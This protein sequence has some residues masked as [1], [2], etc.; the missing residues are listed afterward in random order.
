MSATWSPAVWWA[1][2]RIEVTLF[3][4]VRQYEVRYIGDPFLPFDS[5][6]STNKAYSADCFFSLVSWS[7]SSMPP[8]ARLQIKNARAPPWSV[9]TVVLSRH[10]AIKSAVNGSCACAPADGL[11][12]CILARSVQE[13][14][15]SAQDSHTHVRSERWLYIT[16]Y[17]PPPSQGGNGK[18]RTRDS[19]AKGIICKATGRGLTVAYIWQE[20]G[21]PPSSTTTPAK[22]YAILNYR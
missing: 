13:P 18:E 6:G 3:S 10:R 4:L 8:V 20:R 19:M 22:K 7:G 1:D 15:A 12:R 9:E 17:Q 11:P 2:L 5:R 16:A 21:K 14:A